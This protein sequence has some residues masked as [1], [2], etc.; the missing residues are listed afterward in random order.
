MAERTTVRLTHEQTARAERKAA[1]DELAASV[2]VLMILFKI[3][4]CHSQSDRLF[5]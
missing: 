4:R 2:P 3:E 1:V 5:P